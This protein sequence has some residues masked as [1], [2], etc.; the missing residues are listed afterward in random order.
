MQL[1]LA[2]LKQV[3]STDHHT[4]EAL[5]FKFMQILELWNFLQAFVGR[6]HNDLQ[7]SKRYRVEVSPHCLVA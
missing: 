7:A 5:L 3:T 1:D 2:S 4:F 6:C